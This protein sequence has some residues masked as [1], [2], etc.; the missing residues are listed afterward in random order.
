MSTQHPDFPKAARVALADPQLRRNMGKATSTIRTK[1]ARVVA[2]LA[3]WEELRAAGAAIKDET[4]RHLDTYLTQLEGRVLEAG[5]Q[6]HWA[7]DAAE[8]N[9]LVVNLV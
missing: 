4:L 1:R 7:R 2:E 5:G 6:V 3:D 8:A 9:Q